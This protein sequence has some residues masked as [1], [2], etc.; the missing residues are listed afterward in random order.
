MLSG[1]ESIDSKTSEKLHAD[2][3]KME[4]SSDHH[5]DDIW[6]ESDIYQPNDVVENKKRNRTKK[7]RFIRIV[8][9]LFLVLLSIFLWWL[10]N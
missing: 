2:F 4:N 7:D 3:L 6:V 8:I 9:V 10:K 5:H 1:E